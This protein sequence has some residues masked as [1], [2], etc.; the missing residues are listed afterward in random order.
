MSVWSAKR[1]LTFFFVL[2]LLC[3]AVAAGVFFWSWP[4]PSC[5]D[6]RQNQDESG[7]DCGGVCAAVCQFEARPVRVI[8]SRILPLGAGAYDAA[9]LVENPN[10]NLALEDLA[11]SLRVVDAD[12]LFIVRI[13]GSLSLAPREQWLIFRTN[14]DVGRRQP[15]R[16]LVDFNSPP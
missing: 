9:V 1:K 3:L 12:N 4:R 7:V 8:W 5:Q 2:V 11:Y 16:I 10:A 14:I 15:A 13:N 6:G